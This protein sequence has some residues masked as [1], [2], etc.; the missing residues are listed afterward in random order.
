MRASLARKHR[1]F[2]RKNS[3]R[4]NI[5]L[6]QGNRPVFPATPPRHRPCTEACPHQG[7]VRCLYP[8]PRERFQMHSLERCS[9]LHHG[10]GIRS[11]SFLAEATDLDSST[12]P[13]CKL[14]LV[15]SLNSPF[16][17]VYINFP[18]EY[19]ADAKGGRNK[20]TYQPA[21]WSEAR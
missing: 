19:S 13:P 2:I 8:V 5:F 3:D 1:P 15:R 10:S 11:V 16:I 6:M 7:A 4:K 14:H 20:T 21:V 9:A 12:D 18:S 17:Q